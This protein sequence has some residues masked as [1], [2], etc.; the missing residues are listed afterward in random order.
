MNKFYD[1]SSLLLLADN[2]SQQE[3]NIIISSIT[4]QELEN[5]KTSYNKKINQTS[6]KY[7]I[8]LSKYKYL[9]KEN[10]HLKEIIMSKDKFL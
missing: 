8:L 4:L 10:I 7:Q 1:T 6:T 3:D 5:I 2:L 9:K